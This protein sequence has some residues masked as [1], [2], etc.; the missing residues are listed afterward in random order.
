MLS[1]SCRRATL[2]IGCEHHFSRTTTAVSL[3]RDRFALL[4]AVDGAAALEGEAHRL[5]AVVLQL[6][7][8]KAMRDANG[9]KAV[10]NVPSIKALLVLVFLRSL[11]ELELCLPAHT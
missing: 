5:R 11:D 1:P 7:Q 2:R 8:V 6:G 10:R 9:A 4:Y 3:I